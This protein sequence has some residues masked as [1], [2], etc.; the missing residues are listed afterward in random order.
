[1][2]V[3]NSTLGTAN[4][5]PSI[6]P[7]SGN[8]GSPDGNGKKKSALPTPTVRTPAWAKSNKATLDNLLSKAPKK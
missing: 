8:I 6:P 7:N 4:T 1:M 3:Y 5:S 2:H